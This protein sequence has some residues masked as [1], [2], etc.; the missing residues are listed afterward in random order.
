M[1]F[2]ILTMLVATGYVALLVAGVQN[3]ESWWRQV[4]TVVWLLFLAYFFMLA[5]DTF[6]R[7]RAVFGRV[8]LACMASY[9]LLAWMKPEVS[10]RTQE[11]ELLPHR[12]AVQWWIN[13]HVENPVA[14]RG[15]WESAF[16]AQPGGYPPPGTG[17]Q[18]TWLRGVPIIRAIAVY[19]FA[20]AFGIFGGTLALWNYRRQARSELHD[21][22]S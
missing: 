18:G 1:K 10:N 17:S 3:P 19:N 20:L 6:H 4:G 7:E 14:T 9:L 12:V 15:E 21:V 16:Q 5:A 2:S 11:A 22:S 13:W 8:C